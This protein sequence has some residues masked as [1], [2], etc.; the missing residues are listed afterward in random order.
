LKTKSETDEYADYV[1]RTG[2]KGVQATEANR[3]VYVLKRVDDERAEF[4]FISLWES[5]N[6]IRGFAGED[7]E[8]AVYYPR[9]KEFLLELEPKV[10]HFEVLVKP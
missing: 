10:K 4:F 9:D 7:L 6:A 1:I 5:F 2:V 3:G 8:K